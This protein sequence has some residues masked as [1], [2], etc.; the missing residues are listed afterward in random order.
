M[1][2]TYHKPLSLFSFKTHANRQPCVSSL[3]ITGETHEHWNTLAHLRSLAKMDASSESLSFRNL[4]TG[5]FQ[6]PPRKIKRLDLGNDKLG[7]ATC[8]ETISMDI[9]P[10]SKLLAESGQQ[11][12]GTR[13]E[14]L[15][16]ADSGYAGGDVPKAAES[17]GVSAMLQTHDPT[18]NMGQ[19]SVVVGSSSAPSPRGEDSE[20]Q[21]LLNN[22][23]PPDIAN[24]EGSSSPLQTLDMP[25]LI[26]EPYQDGLRNRLSNQYLPS[27][28]N[29]ETNGSS[30]RRLSL[31]EVRIANQ[32]QRRKS[33]TFESG[34]V[35]AAILRK[36]VEVFAATRPT[37]HQG[38]G[39][40]QNN[41]DVQRLRSGPIDDSGLQAATSMSTP[42]VIGLTSGTTSDAACAI[43]MNE[44][45]NS[46]DGDRFTNYVE[47]DSFA[48]IQ[49]HHHSISRA[50]VAGD[51]ITTFP[52][53]SKHKLALW[54]MNRT[55]THKPGSHLGRILLPA[56]PPPHEPVYT[57]RRA[58]HDAGAEQHEIDE[59]IQDYIDA[60][61]RKDK[62][63]MIDEINFLLTTLRW[64]MGLKDLHQT[65][66]QPFTVFAL[67][68]RPEFVEVDK[69]TLLHKWLNR[70]HETTALQLWEKP[71]IEEGW[72]VLVPAGI[73]SWS[74]VDAPSSERMS[75]P[76]S[77]HPADERP[78]TTWSRRPQD[79]FKSDLKRDNI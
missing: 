64:S 20:A 31:D 58:P 42:A 36:Q 34:Q 23:T 48:W 46:E 43:D 71:D 47:E 75:R 65:T 10:H 12:L 1:T 27:S 40:F 59:A 62:L 16:D 9:S 22:T 70:Q 25:S 7:I 68:R 60:M 55:G 26:S 52:M 66:M 79:G 33:Q 37:L 15:S 18:I 54:N 32:D 3:A 74:G 51:P 73:P 44:S 14:L 4:R 35:T 72:N 67:N 63:R 24:D 21:P 28:I 45:P 56:P 11:A 50:I 2:S 53:I 76:Y 6:R 49:L 8:G 78:N 17:P 29:H 5:R 57:M 61:T 19:N 39:D 69:W 77:P 38:K 41:H 13:P 30:S